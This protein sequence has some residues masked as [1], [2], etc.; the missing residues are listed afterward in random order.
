MSTVFA[1]AQVEELPLTGQHRKVAPGDRR[2]W[3]VTVIT[4]DSATVDYRE[5]A[6]PRDALWVSFVDRF[7]SMYHDED[8]VNDAVDQIDFVMLGEAGQPGRDYTCDLGL[9][10]AKEAGS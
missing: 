8:K 4:G 9:I 7:W 3:R 2:H 10:D 6:E 1:Y 5:G